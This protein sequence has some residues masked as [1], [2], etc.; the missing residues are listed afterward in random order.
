VQELPA[1]EVVFS[2][3]LPSGSAPEISKGEG[4]A[5]LAKLKAMLG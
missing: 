5:K 1:T 2:G 3:A 4:L